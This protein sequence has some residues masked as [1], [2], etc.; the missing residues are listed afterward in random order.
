MDEIMFRG[1]EDNVTIVD[2]YTK[3]I[4]R[5]FDTATAPAYWSFL[6]VRLDETMLI[7]VVKISRNFP[8]KTENKQNKFK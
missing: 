1:M 6:V 8:T 2:I 3:K 5:G 4:L 7:V